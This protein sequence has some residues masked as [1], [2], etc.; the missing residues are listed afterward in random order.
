MLSLKDFKKNAI[1]ID[2]LKSV[3]GGADKGTDGGQF[4]FGYGTSVCDVKNDDGTYDHVFE[5]GRWL[6]NT[7][8]PD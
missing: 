4:F 5:D 7:D 2:G 3:V 1:A 8:A 6:Y